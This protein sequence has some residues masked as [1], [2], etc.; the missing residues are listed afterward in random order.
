MSGYM[1]VKHAGK[2]SVKYYDESGKRRYKRLFINV[3][4]VAPSRQTKKLAEQKAAE[5]FTKHGP[6]PLAEKGIQIKPLFALFH[7]DPGV[8]KGG[9]TT[10]SQGFID[11]R[12]EVLLKL[13]DYVYNTIGLKPH[14]TAEKITAS[15]I[16]GF[17]DLRAKNLKPNTLKRELST[18]KRAFNYALEAAVIEKTPVKRRMTNTSRSTKEKLVVEK[19][20]T[21]SDYQRLRSLPKK[22][23][24]DLLLVICWEAGLRPAEA[25]I[26][27]SIDF[28]HDA[29]IIHVEEGKTGVRTVP[30][31][32]VLSD[33]VL[34]LKV[35][36]IL[37]PVSANAKN[38]A[39]RKLCLKAGVQ[40]RLYGARHAF[41]LRLARKGAP[42]HALRK[43]MGHSS[44]QTT[45]IY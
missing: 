41:C 39:I 36:E 18:I 23:W 24:V 27:S 25:L 11:R 31:S 33:Y 45:Q 42:I 7:K 37:G 4:D 44:I 14:D 19:A 15:V 35:E 16:N 13:E 28:V 8:L 29:G 5:W 20:W 30:L 12:R 6:T 9:K 26:L 43:I 10:L 2:W 32:R 22:K 1:V 21:D 38:Q 40:Q 34:D 17:L 3:G